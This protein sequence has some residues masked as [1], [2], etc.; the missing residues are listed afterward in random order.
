[1]QPLIPMPEQDQREI[2]AGYE[3]QY[4]PSKT[5]GGWGALILLVVLV[6]ALAAAIF[7]FGSTGAGQAPGEPAPSEAPVDPGY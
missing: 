5:G 4:A 7:F 3:E 2:E 1:M 6:A